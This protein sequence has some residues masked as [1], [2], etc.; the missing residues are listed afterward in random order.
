MS[1][2]LKLLESLGLNNADATRLE[3]ILTADEKGKA[4]SQDDLKF[5]HSCNQKIQGK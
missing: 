4:R 3:E 2:R 5:V 1:N